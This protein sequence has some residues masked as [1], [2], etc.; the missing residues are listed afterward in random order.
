MAASYLAF[1]WM[2]Q[3]RTIPGPYI[4][5]AVLGGSSFSL[6]PIVLEYLVEITW[7]ASPEV[8]STICWAGGQLFGGIFILIM[9]SLKDEGGSPGHSAEVG[10]RPPNNMYRALVFQT[11]LAC[12]AL[13]IP[14]FLGLKRLGLGSDKVSSRYSMDGRRA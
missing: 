9:G 13:P 10:D 14:M 5:A 7:P 1:T 6:V 8:S 4:V 3:T 12:I 2:P 11:V